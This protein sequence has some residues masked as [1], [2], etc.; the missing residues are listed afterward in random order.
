MDREQHLHTERVERLPADYSLQQRRKRVAQ[1]PQSKCWWAVRTASVY[2]LIKLLDG[3]AKLTN[4]QAR[5]GRKTEA[6]AARTL[7]KST[8]Q[9]V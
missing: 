2:S 9:A 6:H 8:S 5:F 4:H 3:E 7:Q 1:R